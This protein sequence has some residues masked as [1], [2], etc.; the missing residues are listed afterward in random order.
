MSVS[1]FKR[2]FELAFGIPPKT[3]K[4]NICLQTA[5][6]NLKTGNYK[7]SEIL[8]NIGFDNFAHFS[9]AFK[10]QF[11]FSPSAIAGNKL[12]QIR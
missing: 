5:Y 1:T 2:K 4:R 6:F 12:N 10:K 11:N 7:V 9:Y 8:E 3:W